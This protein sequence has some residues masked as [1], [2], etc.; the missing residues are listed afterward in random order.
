MHL[1]LVIITAATLG[2][3]KQQQRGQSVAAVAPFPLINPSPLAV[4]WPL[5]SFDFLTKLLCR[6]IGF[7][8]NG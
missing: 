6:T 8:L 3:S 1:F 4:R 7:L 5:Y 2:R